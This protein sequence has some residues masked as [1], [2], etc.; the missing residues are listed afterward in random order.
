MDIGQKAPSWRG[1]DQEGND[2]SSD[3]FAGS[4]YV[5][6]FYPKDDTPG[7]TKEAC[8][9]RD[10]PSRCGASVGRQGSTLI[11]CVTVIG[12]SADSVESHKRFV[13]KYNL[14]FTLIA[15]PQKEIIT[16]FG[17]GANHQKRTTFLV[18]AEGC[19][20]KIYQD[21]D[22]ALHAGEIKRDL[23]AFGL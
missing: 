23:A 8:G 5:L 22:V 3:E 20:R 7:C 19:I 12:V 15:D 9:F 1:S 6:Y 14:P 18:D 21:I 16:A 13:E 4:W 2:R 11:E 10:Q 17:I